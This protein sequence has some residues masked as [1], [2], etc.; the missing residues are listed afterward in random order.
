[1]ATIS[2]QVAAVKAELDGT[3]ADLTTITTGVQALRD[4]VTG[5]NTTIQSLQDQLTNLG[6]S[7]EVKA[8]INGLVTE[9]LEVQQS[10]DALAGGFQAPPPTT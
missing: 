2:D 8:A 5:L 4:Q 10:A 3:K 9:G 6:V 1:M 7:P